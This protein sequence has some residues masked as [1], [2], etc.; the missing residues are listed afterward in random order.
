MTSDIEQG[1]SQKQK[2]TAAVSSLTGVLVR[3]TGRT[4]DNAISFPVRFPYIHLSSLKA[5]SIHFN[6]VLS[7]LDAAAQR[8]RG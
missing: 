5:Q 3:S 2:V 7:L 6:I 4:E 1:P 8:P